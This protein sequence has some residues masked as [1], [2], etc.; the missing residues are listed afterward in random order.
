MKPKKPLLLLF[1]ILISHA[2]GFLGSMATS[3]SISTWYITLAK[4]SF[5]PPNW[6]FGPVWLTLYTMMG[7]ALYL[8][9]QQG[10]QKKKIQ[11]AVVVFLAHLVVNAAWSIVFFGQQNLEVAFWVITF[12]WLMILYLIRSFWSI[13]K[14]A[15][16]LLVPYFLWVSFAS[17]LNLSIWRFNL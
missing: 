1:S 9:W 16:Y 10:I 14:T 5:N 8:V 7:V 17:I 12:L 13:N 3:S 2:A 11:Q 6:V 15:A 4:P